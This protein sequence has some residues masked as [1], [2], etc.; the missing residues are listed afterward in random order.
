MI[1][2]Y[3]IT[4]SIFL[5][6]KLYKKTVAVEKR[7][8]FVSCYI[9][10]GDCREVPD[11]DDAHKH[12]QHKHNVCKCREGVNHLS[13][14]GVGKINGKGCALVWRTGYFYTA[15]A[16]F[17]QLFN[18]RKSQSGTLAPSACHLC[19]GRRKFFY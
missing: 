5:P 3:F 16:Q 4:F 6:F 13:D 1:Y 2:L 18:N 7:W 15:L 17:N 9:Y 8:F 12:R 11:L 19:Q 10:V 14:S